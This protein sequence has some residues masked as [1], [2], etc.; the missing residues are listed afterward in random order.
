MHCETEPEAK[1]FCKFLSDSGLIWR[2]ETSYLD[3]NQF[4]IYGTETCYNFNNGSFSR[5]KFY[6][7]YNFVVLEF[8]DFDFSDT[9][10]KIIRDI[11]FVKFYGRISR[12]TDL[13]TSE[14]ARWVDNS[15]SKGLIYYNEIDGEERECLFCHTPEGELLVN[16]GDY[17][18][19]D[20][21]D[22]YVRPFSPVRF[23]K[24]FK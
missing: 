14:Y 6:K 9:Y 15:V 21:T 2:D 20:H 1:I 23:E 13:L 17:L 18:V 4:R 11:D 8:S 7:N 22:G 5:I 12:Y 3:D 16:F 24:Y 10:L 19:D